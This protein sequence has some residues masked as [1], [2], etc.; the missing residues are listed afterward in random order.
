[1]AGPGSI[2]RGSVKYSGLAP[3]PGGSRGSSS[4]ISEIWK[5]GVYPDLGLIL[6]M[7]WNYNQ[8]LLNS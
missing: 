4:R 6:D 3:V 7:I 1:M 8:K 5:P 2:P